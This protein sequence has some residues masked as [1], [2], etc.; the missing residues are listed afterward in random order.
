MS[1]TVVIL[2]GP[3]A[4]GKTTYCKEKLP[5]YYR[6]NQDEMGR[7]EHLK[8][9]FK[10]LKKRHYIV[11]DRMNFDKEQRNRYL[12]AAKLEGFYTK[13]IVL[14]CDYDTCMKRALS[15]TDHPTIKTE[16]EARIAIGGYFKAFRMPTPDEADEI[17]LEK[18]GNV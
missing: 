7:N 10:A 5:S 9:F 14:E 12:E 15:R 3:P 11:V 2:V 16:E 4:S 8:F 13:I 6:I 1:K 17:K 18:S